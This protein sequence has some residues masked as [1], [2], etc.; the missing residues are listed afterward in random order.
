MMK[1]FKWTVPEFGLSRAEKL[2]HKRRRQVRLHGSEHQLSSESVIDDLSGLSTKD[3]K[4]IKGLISGKNNST[5]IAVFYPLFGALLIYLFRGSW[6][7]FETFRDIPL[8][9][10]NEL[11]YSSLAYT[12]VSFKIC[13]ASSIATGS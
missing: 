9:E 3:K 8:P 11:P 7:A 6:I 13:L 5:A 12:T 1:L 4:R 10:R 2:D